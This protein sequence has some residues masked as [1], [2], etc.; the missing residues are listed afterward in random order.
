MP[1]QRDLLAGRL[2]VHVDEDVVGVA[3]LSEGGLD[4]GEGG[5]RRVQVEV[6]AEVHHAE[7][8]SVLFD[9]AGAV[10]G[11][12]AEVVE[13]PHDPRL[14]VEVA[15]DLAVVIGVVAERDRVDASHEQLTCPLGGD[16]EA[17]RHILGVDD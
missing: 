7:L 2:G 5:Q 3:Q 15:V 17:S 14:L 16:P 1:P 13:G 12:A 9:H 8:A 6:A 4:R 11:L 10:A